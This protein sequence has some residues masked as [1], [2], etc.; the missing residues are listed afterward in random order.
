VVVVDRFLTGP[1]MQAIEEQSGGQLDAGEVESLT[2]WATGRLR[3]DV[4][5]L[6]DSPPV[7]PA[8]GPIEH[9]RVQRLLTHVAAAEP[10]RYVVVEAAAGEVV[11]RMVDG[12]RPLLPPVTTTEA[13]VPAE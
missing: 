8:G 2:A 13:E 11:D 12:L 6:L 9:V 7:A 3:P 10:H 5:V 4:S 1:L